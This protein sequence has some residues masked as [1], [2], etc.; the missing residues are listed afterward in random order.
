M[1]TTQPLTVQQVL[2]MREVLQRTILLA[3]R[4]FEESSGCRVESVELT[5]TFAVGAYRKVC[6]VE[7][8]VVL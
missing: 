8:R 1:E 4:N 6:D 7:C 3:I 5:N 2:E